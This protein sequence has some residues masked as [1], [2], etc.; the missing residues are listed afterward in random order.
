VSVWVVPT[1]RAKRPTCPSAAAPWSCRRSP[2][3]SR[4]T[5]RRSRS[6]SLAR[7]QHDHGRDCQ[8]RYRLNHATRPTPSRAPANT[9]QSWDGGA[10]RERF[11]GRAAS[12]WAS[13]PIAPVAPR[14]S[15][16]STPSSRR[17]RAEVRDRAH[18]DVIRVDYRMGT[19]L[20]SP[21]RARPLNRSPAAPAA[22]RDPG[23]GAAQPEAAVPSR[24][25]QGLGLRPRRGCPGRSTNGNGA[26]ERSSG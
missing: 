24:A 26:H 23:V 22:Q 2:R 18:G 21:L 13:I 16:V 12:S 6:Q 8:G 5:A 15:D 7:I 1:R 9:A 20:A 4:S 19:Q 17:L 3:M 14:L 25:S 10:T 11:K